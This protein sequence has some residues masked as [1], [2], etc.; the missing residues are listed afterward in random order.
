MFFAGAYSDAYFE[1]NTEAVFHATKAVFWWNFSVLWRM[2][3]LVSLFSVGVDVVVY[4]FGS[5][6]N[7]LNNGGRIS[8]GLRRLLSRFIIPKVSEWHVF[9]SNM[10]ADRKDIRIHADVLTK[11]DV[12]YKGH[13]AD[14]TLKGDGA[15][16][17]LIL[18]DPY[19]FRRVEYMED[20]KEAR[21]SG[22]K[23]NPEDYWVE[24]PS[25]SFIVMAPEIVSIN[26]THTSTSAVVED[27]SVKGAALR[28]LQSHDAK[29]QSARAISEV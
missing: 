9:L 3:T 7:C 10:L 5:I 28:A 20:K 26:L 25:K 4:N 2:Y 14:K 1:K 19:R 27:P 13:V 23:I 15:L 21:T 8:K 12:L 11:N 16:T 18:E 24:I 6:R 17:C 29:G 22:I